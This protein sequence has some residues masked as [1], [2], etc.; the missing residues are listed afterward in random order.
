MPLTESLAQI[1]AR[2]PWLTIGVWLVVLVIALA[3][4]QNLLGSATTTD[5]RL[6]GRYESERAATLLEEKLRGP[7]KLAE[8]V[9]VQSPSLTVDDE[10]FRAKVEALHEDIVSLGP[11]TI[12]GGISGQ[13]LFHYYHAIDAGPLIAP[14]QM[15]QLLP[16]LRSPDEKT[17]LMHYTLAGTSQEATANVED[18]I[19]KVE[20]ANEADDFLV[21][22]GG[23]ASV[24]F[25]NNELARHDL[26]K[27][28]RFGVPVAL[29]V[30]LLLFGAVVATMLPLGL[31]IVSIVLAMAAVAVIGQYNQL[32]FFVTMMVVMIGL[33]V[34]IDYSLLIV[35]RFKEEMGRGLNP[36]EA[37]VKTGGTAGR[38]VFF[39]GATVVLALI[40]LLIVPASFYQSLALGAILV[41]IAS[42]AATLTL[43]PAVLTLLGPRV[44][45]LSIPFLKR[46]SLKSPE[47]TEQ[48]FWEAITR[49]VTR[50]PIVSILA[51]GVP[52]I[53]LTVFY[54]DI[55]TGLNDVNTFPDVA[56]TKQAFIVLEEEFSVGEVNPAGVLSPAEIASRRRRR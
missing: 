44:D 40:G 2:R 14:E 49:A 17:V 45:L 27:G 22:I 19:H 43:L 8:I 30:L 12:S 1:S 24:A 16:L 28:E 50:Y 37:V 20:E 41:V 5:F 32:V 11:G 25:E 56:K 39:S 53:V 26:E 51:I 34:G 7:E 54:F 23:D 46:F 36:R 9:I 10:A 42:L 4:I 48:G 52:L 38:T 3:L 6:A 31:A 13:P 33:A 35:S 55:R 15:A 29:I 21:L 47:A 18:V